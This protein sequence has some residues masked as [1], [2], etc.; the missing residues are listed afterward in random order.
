[1]QRAQVLG[2]V[3][4]ALYELRQ[5]RVVLS[6]ARRLEDVADDAALLAVPQRDPRLTAIVRISRQARG[7][8]L[9]DGAPVV[10]AVVILCT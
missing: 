1:M 2:G 3:E 5:P 7:G 10:T 6:L 9:C 8:P 4:R